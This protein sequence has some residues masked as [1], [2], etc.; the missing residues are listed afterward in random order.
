MKSILNITIVILILLMSNRGHSQI[1]SNIDS[2]IRSRDFEKAIDVINNELTS[3]NKKDT[4]YIKYLG[5][6]AFCLSNLKRYS[7]LIK[8]YK[9]LIRIDS[10]NKEI[11]YV[12][13]AY[14][15]WNL[16]ELSKA[17]QI[18]LKSLKLNDKIPMTYN[19]L[20]YYHAENK[21]FKK[22][23]HYA[24]LGLKLKLN[25]QEKGMLLSNRGFALYGLGKYE[26][27]LDE[28]DRSIKLFPI[29]SY[30]YFF[31]GLVNLKLNELVKA[32]NDFHKAKELGAIKM[33]QNWIAVYCNN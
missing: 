26:D 14:A 19:N 21:S 24:D 8:E 27:A 2:L 32:C 29:N 12:N 16:G 18:T 1:N 28:L 17:I 25:D 10:K 22:A 15:Y 4:L 33:T 7:I 31:R 11:Y 20:A 5:I 30:P 6:R 23:L 13:L 3:L 9:N